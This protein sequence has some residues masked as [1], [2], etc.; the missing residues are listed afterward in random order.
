MSGSQ[1]KYLARPSDGSVWSINEDLVTYSNKQS[2]EEFPDNLHH[3]HSYDTLIN[4]GFY[5]VTESD[6]NRLSEI[7]NEYYEYL[8]WASRS[9]GHGDAKGGTIEEF[10]SINQKE[11]S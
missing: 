11:K 8:S 1:P 6:F 10:R 9:D 3:E 4:S 7:Q 2:K 5:P